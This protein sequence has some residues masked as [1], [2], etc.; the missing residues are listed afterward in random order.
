MHIRPLLIALSY[1]LMANASQSAPGDQLVAQ[2]NGRIKVNVEGNVSEVSFLNVTSADINRFLEAQVRKWEFHPM[3]VNGQP[4]STDAG[5]KF[6]LLANFDG[7]GKLQQIAFQDVIIEPTELELSAIK[8]N[9]TGV[10]QSR[11]V[12]PQYPYVPLKKGVGAELE[13]AV[14]VL[15]DG[16]IGDTAVSEMILLGADKYASASL[17]KQY[18]KDFSESALSAVKKWKYSS[19]LMTQS[20]CIN[21]CTGLISVNYELRTAPWMRYTEVKVP[22]IPWLIVEQ[23]KDVEAKKS[24]LLV[25]KQQPSSLPIDAGS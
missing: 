2:V 13:L 24:Q 8:A 18:Q 11:R 10:D 19:A 6:R 21:G 22:E 17:L 7:A 1:L 25:F 16:T 20:N 15:P 3:K 23:V 4:V 14:K 5:F 12:S 9:Q